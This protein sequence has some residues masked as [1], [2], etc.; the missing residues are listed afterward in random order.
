MARRSG[1]PVWWLDSASV[2]ALGYPL[3]FS[4]RVVVY[5]PLIGAVESRRQRMPFWSEKALVAPRFEDVALMMLR[6][7]PVGAR[8]VL[9][10]NRDRVNASY[11]LRRVIEER[12]LTRAT[13]ARFQDLVAAI[14]SEGS[15]ISTAFLVRKTRSSSLR[16]P[17]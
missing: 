1:V 7:D 15:P 13:L 2:S 4:P 12:M 8:I 5:A 16:G 17:L 14:P 3:D 10:R 9:E 6:I 11:L